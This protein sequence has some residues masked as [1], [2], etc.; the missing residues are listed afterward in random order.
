LSV[1]LKPNRS[2]SI[3]VDAARLRQA[4]ASKALFGLP[5]RRGLE[6]PCQCVFTPSF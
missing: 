2:E 1:M 5:V 3:I 4:S 6:V